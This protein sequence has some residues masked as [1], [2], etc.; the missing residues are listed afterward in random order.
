VVAV[1]HLLLAVMPQIPL[2]RV[3]VALAALEPH[4]A[5]LVLQ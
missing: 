2:L 5:F 3:V 1:A 4:L